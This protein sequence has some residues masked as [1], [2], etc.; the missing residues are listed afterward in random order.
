M[1]PQSSDP[2]QKP[3][4]SY[5]MCALRMAIQ[6]SQR[7]VAEVA[8]RATMTT[9]SLQRILSGT[10]TPTL[11]QIT[12]IFEACD[13]NPEICQTATRLGYDRLIHSIGLRYLDA[14]IPYLFEAVHE[15]MQDGDEAIDP[16]FAEADARALKE[17]WAAAIARR[18]AFYDEITKA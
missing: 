15:T 2:G 7:P 13:V 12:K 8:R 3:R 18:R 17:R 16:R 14:I 1:I 5:V 10:T 4:H 11:A 9:R 6:H